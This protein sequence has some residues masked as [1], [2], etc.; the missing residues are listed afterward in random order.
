[1]SRHPHPEV[2]KYHRDEKISLKLTNYIQVGSNVK[3]NKNEHYQNITMESDFQRHIKDGYIMIL[4]CLW[5]WEGRVKHQRY[6]K[7]T[8]K[9]GAKL[10]FSAKGKRLRL[11]GLKCSFNALTSLKKC[12]KAYISIIQHYD[13]IHG[14]LD[15]IRTLL[16]LLY[17]LL[18]YT[19]SL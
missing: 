18:L 13:P 11:L 10:G 8:R 17:S 5:D 1:M 14:T 6:I 3:V 4:R 15:Y 12:K 2:N 19:F 16:A 9:F 7:K